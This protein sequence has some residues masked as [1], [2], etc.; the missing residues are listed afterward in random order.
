MQVIGLCRFSYPAI[1]GFQVEHGTMAERIAYLYSDARMEERFRL[2]ETV[3]LPSLRAQSDPDFDLVIVTGDSLPRQHRDRLCD[4]TAGLPQVRIAAEPPRRHREV[5]KE[6]LN[7]ARRDPDRPC[8]Q[9]R[10]DDDDAV[11]GEFVERLRE[12]AADCAPLLAKTDTAAIDF[13]RGYI[14]EFSAAGI[15]ATD[16]AVH[17]YF[18]AALA[19]Y[20]A[21][22]CRKSVMNFAHHRI[23]HHMPTVTVTDVPMWVRSHNRFNDSRQERARPAA[24]APLTPKQEREFAT[25]FGIDA[26]RVRAVFSAGQDGAGGPPGAPGRR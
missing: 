24:V 21:G 18:T 15:A 11:A 5:M 17:P 25:V 1:G 13:N 10:F 3:A 7:R 9:F 2:F 19:M 14:A 12:T 22:G 20:A 16:P 26:A 8:L 23:H 6:L 4:L